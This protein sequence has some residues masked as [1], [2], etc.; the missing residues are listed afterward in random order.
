[1]GQT[2]MMGL[3][4]DSLAERAIREIAADP[5]RGLRRMV[6]LGSEM[7]RGRSQREFFTLTQAMLSDPD[8]PYYALLTR[9]VRRTAHETLKRFAVDL[10]WNCWTE[11]AARIRRFETETGVQAP[12]SISLELDGRLGLELLTG[13]L[14]DAQRV[15]CCA[16]LCFAGNEA[17]AYDGLRLAQ[18]FPENAFALLAPPAVLDEAMTA[19]AADCPNVIVSVETAAGYADAAARLRRA[20]CLF[21][22]HRFYRDAHEAHDILSGAWIERVLGEEGLCVTA[23]ARSDCPPETA[24]QVGQYMLNCRTGQRYAVVALD[25]FTDEHR[26]DRIM[27]EGRGRF[28]GVCADGTVI[29]HRAGKPV[30]T[31][32]N[33]RAQDFV[34]ILRAE[35][36]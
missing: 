28:F 2:E 31:A 9:T 5:R 26:V 8:S 30:R 36:L 13:L 32:A 12:W 21:G 15:G 35:S 23:V 25:F 10:A 27:S 34:S 16:V 29:A 19:R 24:E 20:G 6:D 33:I 18:R 7:A 17:G 11:G 1:M 4:V 22:L 14:T 3:V